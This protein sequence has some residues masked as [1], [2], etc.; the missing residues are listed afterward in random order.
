MTIKRVALITPPYHSGVVESAGTWLNVGFVYV[1]GSLR[2]AGYEVDYYDAMSLWHKWP[3]IEARIRAFNPDVV[4]TTSFT[5]SIGHALE[6]TALAKEINPDVVTVH[7]NVHA[8][9]CYDEML[10]AEHDTVDFIVRGE[11]EVTLVKLLD[12]LN[13]GGDPACVPGLSFWRDGAVVTTPKAASIQDLDAL[14]MAWDL[15]EWP[16]YTYRAKNNARL[17]I[18]SSSRGC[19]EKCS[20]C[21]QQL[22]WERS[23]RA[24]SAE[25]F[26]AELELLRDSYGV[27]V[28]MLSDEIPT[29]DRERWVRILDL[30][31]ERKVGVKLLMETRVDDILRD[32]DIMDKYREAGV[33]HIYV[34]VEAGDQ[35]TLDL[36]NK[37]TK[38]EQSKAAIDIINNA[39]IVSETSFVL[40]MPDDTPESIA[41]TIELAKHYNPD[42]AFFLA[43]APW[44]YAELYPELEPYV[45]TKDYRK[46][47]LVEPVIKPKAM[48]VEELER[49]LGRASQ[50]FYMHK[51]QKLHDLSP[52]KQ[53]FMVAV[54]DILINNSYLAVQMRSMMKEGKQMP[55]EVQALLKSIKT[56]RG[57]AG[58]SD[59]PHTFAPIP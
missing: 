7:G 50:K 54:L 29:F 19:M 47:N 3:E 2:A 31:I 36:F 23:W 38:V 20:F 10:K 22:F 12:C 56:V 57:N 11:G 14:P 16:I 9:F 51:F 44:P 49:E 27:E 53:T 17:A 26:V 48:T 40:G 8:T 32:A 15:V 18:V 25:N 21:S 41:A 37:N 55:P 24:R 33:E 34:G 5:A 46:Y 42:M 45:A 39:D 6:L 13:Q 4:A 59:H 28:A 30:M 52:W 58:A 35:A 1:A 43:I